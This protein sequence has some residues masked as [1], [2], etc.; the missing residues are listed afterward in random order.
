[1]NNNKKNNKT[2]TKTKRQWIKQIQNDVDDYW[3]DVFQ[4]QNLGCCCGCPICNPYYGDNLAYFVMQDEWIYRD[5]DM[6]PWM[7]TVW[8]IM[9]DWFVASNGIKTTP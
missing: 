8:P 7:P 9:T 2:K 1:M 5:T 6:T 3:D 4:E